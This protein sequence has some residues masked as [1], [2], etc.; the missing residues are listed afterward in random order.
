MGPTRIWDDAWKQNSKSTRVDQQKVFTVELVKKIGS[1]ADLGP[2]VT[3]A[4]LPI[5]RKTPYIRKFSGKVTF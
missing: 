2:Q 3:E 5:K 4:G 1:S